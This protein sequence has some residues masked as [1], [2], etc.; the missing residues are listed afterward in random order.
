MSVFLIVIY[1]LL[2]IMYDAGK[3]TIVLASAGDPTA[4]L[5]IYEHADERDP[6]HKLEA[7]QIDYFT[8]ISQ[9]WIPKN[10]HNEAEG[11][12]NGYSYIAYTFYIE[13]T[14][15]EKMNYWYELILDDVIKNVDEAL[16]V[17]IFLNDEKTVYAKLNSTTNEPEIGTKEFFSAEKIAVENRL[18]IESGEVD[19]CTIVIWIEGDDPDC[20]DD[21]IGG[22][23][24]MHMEIMEQHIAQD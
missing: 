11:G 23:M 24:K 22:E 8:N 9:D 21:L 2:R 7:E 18:G 6:K 16:R 14:S 4:G 10:I 3:F 5:I 17:M 15:D 19:K 12:H 20:I 13:N 1:Y